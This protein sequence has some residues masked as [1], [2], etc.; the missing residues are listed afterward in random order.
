[1]KSFKKE[2]YLLAGIA[3]FGLSGTAMATAVGILDT[4]DCG[5]GTV[6]VSATQIT[7]GGTSP[8]C[9]VTGGNT[10]VTY[11]GGGGGT[12]GGNVQGTIMNL[13]LGP[14]STINDFMT[15]LVPTAYTL[16]FELTQLG[17]GS[18]NTDCN[19]TAVGQSC[20]A[21]AGSPFVLTDEGPSLTTVTLAVAGFINDGT[22]TSQWTGLFSTNLNETALA[23][24]STEG[25]GGSI[26]STAAGHFTLSAIPE[27]STVTMFL[28]GGIALLGIGRRRR[29]S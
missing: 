5:G 28:V 12:L 9:V 11:S 18:L 19:L 15:F 14:P 2:I 4:S 8:N 29:K 3:C 16:D 20:S 10:S 27:P 13:I 17:P 21:A 26:T 6:T 1:M 23:I 24:Q 22:G 25:T 7:W